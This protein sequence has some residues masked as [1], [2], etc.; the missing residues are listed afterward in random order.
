MVSRAVVVVG[1]IVFALAGVITAAYEVFLT[2]LRAGSTLLWLTIPLAIGSNIVLPRL[3]RSI[4]GSALMGATPVLTWIVT[5]IALQLGRR[6]GDVLI[7]TQPQDLMYAGYA[8]FF[9]GMLAGVVTVAISG[10]RHDT[11]TGDAP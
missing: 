3:A 11:H 5:M 1:A 7:P 2:P 6:E 10:G 9:L 4:N 8:V